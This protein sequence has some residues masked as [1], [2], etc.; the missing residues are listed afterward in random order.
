M[1]GSCISG[2][3]PLIQDDTKKS[4]SSF[5]VNHVYH[6]NGGPVDSHALEYCEN[7]YVRY[8]SGVR[9]LLCPVGM[10]SSNVGI[11]DSTDKDA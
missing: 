7:R 6:N 3:H 1:F 2:R 8:R 9:S 4:S 11:A 10:E 5:T